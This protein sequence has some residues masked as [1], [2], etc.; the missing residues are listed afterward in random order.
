MP[1][2]PRH[3]LFALA[4]AVAAVRPAAPATDVKPAAP[5]LT[6]R[7]GEALSD[8][9]LARIGSVRPRNSGRVKA[10]AFAPDGKVFA[11]AGEGLPRL[12]DAATGAE[13]PQR[14]AGAA[15]W[16]GL[17]AF[18][19]DGKQLVADTVVSSDHALVLWD[20][21]TGRELWNIPAQPQC[22]AFAPGGKLLACG[23]DSGTITLRDAATG[24]VQAK[25]KGHDGA[26][27]ALV[28][29]GDGR[30]LTSAS[31]D[32][33][34]VRVWDVATGKELSR[35]VH[36]DFRGAVALSADGKTLVVQTEEAAVR[37]LDAASGKERF[38]LTKGPRE[39]EAYM[40][41]GTA[42]STDGRFLA[43][44]GG[45]KAPL[46]VWDVGTRKRLRPPGGH[47][48][49][50]NVVALAPDGRTAVTGGSDG[51][52][53]FWDVLTGTHRLVTHDS[54]P[55]LAEVF[56][57]PDGKRVAG[58]DAEALGLWDPDGG[59]Q[60]AMLPTGAVAPDGK[61]FAWVAPDFTIHLRDLA[62][63]KDVRQLPGHRGR[64]TCAFSPDGKLLAS[65]SGTD[66]ATR[67]W[68]PATGK[69][70]RELPGPSSELTALQFSADGRLLLVAGVWNN[71][72]RAVRLW[73]AATG[74]D[75]ARAAQ[76][77]GSPIALAPD[78]KLLAQQT[79]DPKTGGDKC[80][81][82]DTA[83]GKV[84]REL[85]GPDLGSNVFRFQENRVDPLLFAPD[86]R[87]LAA[88][89]GPT[90]E[91]V[92]LWNPA[93]GKERRRLKGHTNRVSA[94]AFAP[95]GRTV[96]TSDQNG[97]VFLWE[98]GTG[99]QRH[100]FKSP[101]G[102]VSLLAFS[103]DGRMLA[104]GKRGE[105]FLLVWDVTGLGGPSRPRPEKYADKVLEG[106][107]GDLAAPDAARASKACWRL[108]EVPGQ[109]VPL[110][111]ARL[112]PAPASDPRLLDQ[113]IAD[114][115][116]NRFTVREKATR[117]LA[118][119]GEVAEPLLRK[120][121]AG[122]PPLEAVR[123]MNRLLEAITSRSLSPDVVQ[124]LRAVEVLEHVGTTEA[125]A[126]LRVLAGGAAGHPVTEE[127]RATLRRL[128]KRA[129]GT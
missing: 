27:V 77:Q 59:R 103:P 108:A 107:W 29:A 120:A 97:G 1:A 116:S 47:P 7:Y 114:L 45:W 17:V 15:D 85:R 37:L 86:G 109:A 126:A 100:H 35:A 10:V 9:I 110:L 72:Q 122:N 56:F 96:A 129:A 40:A 93:T 125:R 3:L 89:A 79:Q 67:L 123:R 50:M 30:T 44:V 13:L 34:T 99:G 73:D 115:S 83:T 62:S 52:V 12:W 64:A 69:L 57:L 88:L 4:L 23:D 54:P 87:T 16:S 105:R 71:G 14:L 38:A 49:W 58:G 91:E 76:D 84:L 78:G 6:D 60:L 25:L 32:D 106:L 42:I 5:A 113:L 28:F 33:R 31:G 118:R 74:K 81:L 92:A 8:D 18:S 111:R 26:V 128:E 22:I 90:G 95:D 101:P 65:A 51:A 43:T 82:R 117:E 55:G 121:L 2:R 119:L 41:A 39:D 68:D 11:S 124:A 20:V 80:V 98:L 53:Y 61:R 24:Q 21:A 94:V 70:L 63:G 104:A 46:L 66:R 102:G 127:A 112:R 36:D 19:A 48:Q 75:M